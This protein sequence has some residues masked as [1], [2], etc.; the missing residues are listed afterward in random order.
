MSPTKVHLRGGGTASLDPYRIA[1]EYGALILNTTDGA[2]VFAP[3]Q[4]TACVPEDVDIQ[5]TQP[6]SEPDIGVGSDS[7]FRI[8][9]A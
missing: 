3:G 5:W 4:W 9:F 8:P 6:P 7:E 1:V 2:V